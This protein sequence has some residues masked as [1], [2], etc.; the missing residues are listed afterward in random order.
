MAK[1]E[2]VISVEF[3]GPINQNYRCPALQTTVRGRFDLHRVAEPQAGKLFGKWPEP[4][5]SQVLEYDFSTEAG[6][7]I[8]PLYEAKF[9]ALREKIEGMGQKLPEQRQVFKIDAA[10]L[11]YWLRGLVQ[12]GDA[13]ILAGTIPEVAGT[14]R[15]RFHSAQPVEPLDKLTAAIERQSELQVQLIEAITKLAGK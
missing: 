15:T 7:I 13:K 5:P 9:A 2:T 11:A 4:I 10:T 14:P 12:T 1:T 3:D 6:C 8:E